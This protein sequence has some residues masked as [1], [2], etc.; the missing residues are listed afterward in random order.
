MKKY[1]YILL[2]WDGNLAK[3]LDIWLEAFD[4]VLIQE[5]FE[6]SGEQIASLFGDSVAHLRVLGVQKPDAALDEIDKIAKRRLPNVEL[7][8]DAR[9]VIKELHHRGKK[10]AL[11]TSSIHEN[12]EHLLEKHKII[13]FFD[14]IIAGDD[15][16][17]HKPHPEQLEKALAGL[18][19]TKEH[20]IIIGDSDKDLGAARN[21]GIDSILFYPP[22][23]KK[24]Y[25]ITKLKELGP[26]YILDD[27]K[28]VLNTV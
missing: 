28:D 24:F 27:F 7:Y 26:T 11:I 16:T 18:G 13:S 3:T 5:G 22:E 6:L 19:G 10:L 9:Q 12:V 14:V 2:D 21:F 8:P 4:E 17:H 23:H 15:I 25:D 20:A 1:E